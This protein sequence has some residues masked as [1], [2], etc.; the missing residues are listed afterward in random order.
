MLRITADCSRASAFISAARTCFALVVATTDARSSRLFL[1]SH[2]P[3][4]ESASMI[5]TTTPKPSARRAPIRICLR[6]IWVFQAG[7]PARG[8]PPGGRLTLLDARNDEQGPEGIQ[9][10]LIPVY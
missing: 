6:T 4:N 5:A 9:E 2:M 7:G 1:P 3:A 8:R 10:N